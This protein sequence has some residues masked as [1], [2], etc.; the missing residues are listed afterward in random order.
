MDAPLYA[1]MGEPLDKLT[2]CAIINAIL[3]YVI[4]K[5]LSLILL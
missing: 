2:K 4:F 5:L 3:R 1:P